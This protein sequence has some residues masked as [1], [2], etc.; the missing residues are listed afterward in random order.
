MEGVKVFDLE[1]AKAKKT[2]NELCVVHINA[3]TAARDEI[4]GCINDYIT[5]LRR[6]NIKPEDFERIS[7]LLGRLKPNAA[8]KA[9]KD[10]TEDGGKLGGFAKYGGAI[11]LIGSGER[12]ER[13]RADC[14][15]DGGG[16]G[17]IDDYAGTAYNYSTS[18]D[19]AL[20]KCRAENGKDGKFRDYAFRID[21]GRD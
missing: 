3:W 2:V 10:A 6:N 15:V 20:R 13:V 12:Y 19:R 21:R 8:I 18:Y 11:C 14:K 1:A 5:A 9:I 4:S 7:C 16:F 17:D